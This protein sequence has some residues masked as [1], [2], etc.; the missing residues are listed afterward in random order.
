[1]KINLIFGLILSLILLLDVTSK[2]TPLFL[3]LLI[4]IIIRPK[5]ISQNFFLFL[6]LS[7]LLIGYRFIIC[8]SNECSDNQLVLIIIQTFTFLFLVLT[9]TSSNNTLLKFLISSTKVSIVIICFITLA[10]NLFT[11]LGIDFL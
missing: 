4:L 3:L 10:G 1:M 6:P 11:F 7:I 2:I 9:K 8:S 5:K